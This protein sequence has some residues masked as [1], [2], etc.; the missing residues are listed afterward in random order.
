MIVF[1]VLHCMDHRGCFFEDDGVL[2]RYHVLL[3][4]GV[5]HFILII[6]ARGGVP[7]SNPLKQTIGGP[8]A[9]LHYYSEKSRPLFMTAAITDLEFSKGVFP[10]Q[11]FICGCAV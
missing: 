1:S 5:R 6:I 4:S 8:R 2:T 10:P 11:N 3:V 7:F 9:S